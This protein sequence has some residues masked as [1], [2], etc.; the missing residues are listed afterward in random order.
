M[1]R[2]EFLTG[3]AALGATVLMPRGGDLAAIDREDAVR[4]IPR[5]KA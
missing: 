3:I 2:R 4:L 5:L 1:V